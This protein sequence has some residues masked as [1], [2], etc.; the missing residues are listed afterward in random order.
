LPL[1]PGYLFLHGDG[2]AR[3]AALETKLV[4]RVLTVQD[5]LQLHADLTRVYHLMT[6][7]LPLTPEER[8][9]AGALVEI[10]SGPLAGLEGKILRRGKRFKFLVEVQFLQRGVSAEVENWMV[11]PL[12]GQRPVVSV[13]AGRT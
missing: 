11:R 4:A 9:D 2:Q 8:L 1:F 7:G 10:I 12:A 5:Q 3:V 6:A 13:T